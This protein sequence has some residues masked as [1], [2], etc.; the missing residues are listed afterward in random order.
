[1]CNTVR[2]KCNLQGFKVHI[3]PKFTKPVYHMVGIT[4]ETL[5]P[6]RLYLME[7]FGIHM[8]SW[9][10]ETPTVAEGSELQA[11][12]AFQDSAQ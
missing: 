4:D 5:N 10:F 7:G 11:A 1:M 12:L 2:T 9:S 8:N 3:N 6:K